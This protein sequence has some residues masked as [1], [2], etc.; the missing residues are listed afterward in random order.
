MSWSDVWKEVSVATW[1]LTYVVLGLASP[2]KLQPVRRHRANLLSLGHDTFFF[3]TVQ[4]EGGGGGG[5]K[6]QTY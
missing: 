3:L 5:K 2:R 4:P 1:M 6:Y